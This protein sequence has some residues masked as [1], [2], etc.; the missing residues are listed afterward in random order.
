MW[1]F[2]VGTDVLGFSQLNSYAIYQLAVRSLTTFPS[3][4]NSFIIITFTIQG[5]GKYLRIQ[6][7]LK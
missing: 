7:K 3:L 5:L 6:K 4:S 1:Q 2:E